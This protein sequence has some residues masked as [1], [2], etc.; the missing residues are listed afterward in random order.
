MGTSFIRETRDAS[1]STRSCTQKCLANV[2]AAA[3]QDTSG[4]ASAISW[5]QSAEIFV[6]EEMKNNPGNS[7]EESETSRNRK[8]LR[9]D[10]PNIA[11]VEEKLEF[12]VDLRIEGIAHDVI[13]KDEERLGPNTRSGGKIEDRLIHEIY[14]G[15]S[16]KTRQLYDLQRGNQTH[17]P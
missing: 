15:R 2:A 13:L 14:S 16:E 11:H 1:T 17:H 10:V 6:K 5:T 12:K 7:T 8:V 3:E 4:S 9:S